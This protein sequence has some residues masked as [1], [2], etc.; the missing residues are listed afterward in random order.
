MFF[1]NQSGDF[2]KAV[3]DMLFSFCDHLPWADGPHKHKKLSEE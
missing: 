3:L 1:K 2:S